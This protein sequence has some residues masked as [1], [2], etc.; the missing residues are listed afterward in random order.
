MHKHGFV[1][2]IVITNICRFLS[3]SMAFDGVIGELQ[4]R[5]DNYVAE[6]SE[7]EVPGK[8]GMGVLL[9]TCMDSRIVPHEIFGLKIGDIKVIRNA[10][11][12]LNQEV[13]K[14]VIIASHLLNCH[15]IVIM[16]HTKCAMASGSSESIRSKLTEIS[17]DKF[18]NFNP[19]MITDTRAK[20]ESDVNTLRNH[21]QLPEDVV[22]HGCIY[23]V[24]SGKVSWV[25]P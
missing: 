9:I 3:T 12:Q 5:N 13:E 23:D 22:V 6:F 21:D 17:G 16:P 1:I 7:S 8:A 14:D 2:G 10:G 24:E 25:I 20:L 15:T 11:G 19:S 4:K 18:S